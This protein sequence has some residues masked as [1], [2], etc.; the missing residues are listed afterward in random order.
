MK[1]RLEKDFKHMFDFIE[2][3]TGTSE[4]VNLEKFIQSEIKLA[5]QEK[6]KEIRS[7]SQQ[8]EESPSAITTGY[9]IGYKVG[10]ERGY[11]NALE[12]AASLLEK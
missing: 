10:R 11:K 8:I 3:Q 1:E 12:S 4:R 2:L 5:L 6:A 7:L 9:V